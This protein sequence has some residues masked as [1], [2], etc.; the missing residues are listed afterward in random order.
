MFHKVVN[1]PHLKAVVLA[2]LLT[3]L[4]KY[5]HTPTEKYF[6]VDG[7]TNMVLKLLITAKANICSKST[8]KTME[9]RPWML[10]QVFLV[11][12]EQ[13]YTLPSKHLP[14]KV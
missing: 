6:P 3:Y 14:K 2:S 10:I 7:T 4:K 8:I 1:I 5:L 12:L 13:V 11:D 9:Q